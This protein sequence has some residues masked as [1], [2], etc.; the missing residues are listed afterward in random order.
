MPDIRDVLPN[1]CYSLDFFPSGYR[2]FRAL[3]DGIRPALGK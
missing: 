3:K 2:M 1:S